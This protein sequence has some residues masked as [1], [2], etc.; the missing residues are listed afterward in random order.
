ML[1]LNIKINRPEESIEM[2]GK[3]TSQLNNIQMEELIL[4]QGVF[5]QYIENDRNAI[6]L[7]HK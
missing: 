3:Y 4:F 6:S 7:I 5:N 1:R 2:I